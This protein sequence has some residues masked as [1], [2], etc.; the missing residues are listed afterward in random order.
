MIGCP[1]LTVAEKTDTRYPCIALGH[2]GDRFDH[3]L[4]FV[5]AGTEPATEMRL[6]DRFPVEGDTGAVL[7]RSRGAQWADRPVLASAPTVL[8]STSPVA[9]TQI[10]HTD[11]A[12][13]TLDL[14]LGQRDGPGGDWDEAHGS[15]APGALCAISDR[16]ST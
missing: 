5:N 4:E 10:L 16:A 3:V 1:A 8:S 2:P 14:Y 7:S 12:I 6:V 11:G 15:D 9:G 13:C